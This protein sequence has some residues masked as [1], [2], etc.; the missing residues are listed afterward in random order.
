ML[1]YLI[2]CVYY[3]RRKN[4][5]TNIKYYANVQKCGKHLQ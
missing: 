4:I 2:H 3:K 1:M 5:I